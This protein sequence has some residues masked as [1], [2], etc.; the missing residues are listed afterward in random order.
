LKRYLSIYSFLSQLI[1]FSDLS[2]EK[3]FIFGKFLLKKLPTINDPLPFGVLED[4]DIE[5]YKIVNK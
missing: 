4:A 1:P 2:L 5:S 3:L